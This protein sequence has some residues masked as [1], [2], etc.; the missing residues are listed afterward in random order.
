MW[1]PTTTR[2]L[3][4]NG[5]TVRK[6]VAAI[7]DTVACMET[8]REWVTTEKGACDGDEHYNV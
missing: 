2:S 6:N 5:K 7:K 1:L 3:R 8:R 4:Q